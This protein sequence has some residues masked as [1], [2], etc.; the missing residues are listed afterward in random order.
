MAEEGCSQSSRRSDFHDEELRC[1]LAQ[2]DDFVGVR[3]MRQVLGLTVCQS[4]D[5]R[6][7]FQEIPYQCPEVLFEGIQQ[8]ILTPAL[9]NAYLGYTSV[10]PR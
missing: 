7:C 6:F 2:T 9:L 5:A 10:E 1:H 8:Y 3:R 4:F